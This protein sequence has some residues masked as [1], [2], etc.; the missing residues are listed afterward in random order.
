MFSSDLRDDPQIFWEYR[1][2][3]ED[4][5]SGLVPV[6][7]DMEATNTTWADKEE[8]KGTRHLRHILLGEEYGVQI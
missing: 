3:M 4:W 8:V 1:R 7:A 5:D 6:V 2:I